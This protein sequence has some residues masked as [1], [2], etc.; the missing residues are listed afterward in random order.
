[1]LVAQRNGPSD[2]GVFLEQ[3]NHPLGVAL[4]PTSVSEGLTQRLAAQ[5]RGKQRFHVPQTWL[6]FGRSS[7]VLKGGLNGRVQVGRAGGQLPK[8]PAY[9]R[10]HSL[11][12]GQQVVPN[13]VAAVGPFG[14]AGVFPPCH[15]VGLG[16]GQEFVFWDV[17][18]RFQTPPIPREHAAQGER[19]GVAHGLEQPRLGLV[20]GVVGR[21]HGVGAVG[22]PNR[23]QPRLSGL[24][25]LALKPLRASLQ[26]FRLQVEF[27]K[28]PSKPFGE[29][30]DE[31]GVGLTR[32]PAGTVVHMGDH[33]GHAKRT[34]DMQQHGRVDAPTGPHDHGLALGPSGADQGVVHML[35]EGGH[36]SKQDLRAATLSRHS[37]YS[38]SP[39]AN[40]VSAPP[41]VAST[42]PVSA[43]CIRLRM[44]TL[45]SQS[46]WVST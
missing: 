24:V 46:P 2:L 8:M 19:V 45:K 5:G 11:Q 3:V 38:S 10:L 6:Q 29:F 34:Q 18:Q 12:R 40:R 33:G 25:G 22:M 37:S 44:T 41:T 36:R 4:G 26:L 20:V 28:R 35:P 31:R 30:R 21:Q 15:V 7:D 43:R 17:K 14:V 39:W 1:M 9:P 13:L 42:R 23:L 32:F 16:V 27:L